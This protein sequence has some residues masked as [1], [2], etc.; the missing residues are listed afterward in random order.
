MGRL[1]SRV[2]G[3]ALGQCDFFLSPFPAPV[4]QGVL[5]RLPTAVCTTGWIG[6]RGRWEAETVSGRMGTVF[7]EWGGCSVPRAFGR[8]WLVFGGVGLAFGGMGWGPGLVLV[9]G[10]LS[11]EGCGLV[12]GKWGRAGGGRGL[13]LGGGG[14]GQGRW[15]LV[16]V[17]GGR[18]HAPCSRCFALDG[19]VRALSSR[20]FSLSSL[21]DAPS[22]RCFSL[23]SRVDA[24]SSRCFSVFSRVDAPSTRLDTVLQEPQT[25]FT[26]RNQ[27]NRRMRS[28]IG[29]AASG[30]IQAKTGRRRRRPITHGADREGR[31]G[32]DNVPGAALSG[33]KS[34]E[35]LSP[36]PERRERGAAM[37]AVLAFGARQCARRSARRSDVPRWPTASRRS[38]RWT[39]SGR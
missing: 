32:E 23:S 10:W 38:T 13:V 1:R 3:A 25:A 4:A 22:G 19:R 37:N 29:R 20:C 24:P 5:V 30:P 11:R 35:P 9:R 14:L 2:E 39:G 26:A 6:K 31:N 18:L 12:V 34:S 8:G 27:R 33:C 16:D 21:V 36:L 15:G 17:A 28:V 7:G